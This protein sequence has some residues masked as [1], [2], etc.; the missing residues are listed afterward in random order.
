MGEKV[1]VFTIASKNYLPHVRVLFS[2][3]KEHHPDFGRYLILCDEVEGYFDPAAE[4][5]TVI[6]AADAGD[7]CP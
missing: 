5:F 6:P 1:G 4:D 3:L 2:S 7:L